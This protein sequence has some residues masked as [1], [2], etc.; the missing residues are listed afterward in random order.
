MDYANSIGLEYHAELVEP[1]N[2]QRSTA[3]LDA[4]DFQVQPILKYY[5]H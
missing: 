3:I 2:G 1:T 4:S 5:F